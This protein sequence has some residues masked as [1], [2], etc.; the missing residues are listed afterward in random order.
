MW[1]FASNS[2]WNTPLGDGATGVSA[3]LSGAATYTNISN[4]FGESV[5][6]AGAPD[7]NVDQ[8]NSNVYAEG[9]ISVINKD[10]RYSI[11]SNY[12]QNGAIEFY[13]YYNGPGYGNHVNWLWYDTDL[14][15]S[16]LFTNLSPHKGGNSFART[17]VAGTSSAAG[18]IRTFDITYAQTHGYFPHMLEVEMPGSKMNYNGG[19]AVWPGNGQDNNASTSY[20]A[21]ANGVPMGG[22]MFIPQS[23]AMPAGLSQI[24]QWVFRT[25]QKFGF[26]LVDR[27]DNAFSFRAEG[28]VPQATIAPLQN[29]N[30]GAVLPLIKRMTNQYNGTTGTLNGPGNRL[31]PLAPAP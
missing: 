2:I 19:K 27:N 26:L 30:F 16:G 22:T 7:K 8:N 9:H 18:V 5:W 23:T 28:N 4:G 3:N 31:A 13:K 14:R 29:G 15:G 1:P 11:T 24:T 25:G 20:T 6:N 10:T 17:H 12:G 21:G